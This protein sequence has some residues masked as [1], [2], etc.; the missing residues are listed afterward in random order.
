MLEIRFSRRHI[1][2]FNKMNILAIYLF[3]SQAIGKAHPLSD[4]DIGVVFKKPEKYKDKTLQPYLELYQ[5]FTEVLPKDY[6]QHRFKMKGHEFDLVFLQ[7]APIHVQFN[8]IRDAR[9]LY[10][11]NREKRLDY[12]EY[13]LKRYCDLKYFYDLHYK[14][15]LE[16]I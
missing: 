6:L 5:I 14:S 9:I 13:I 10:E 1:N 3:G 15:V 8:A 4:V 11:S 16:R 7:F 2:Q 12:E